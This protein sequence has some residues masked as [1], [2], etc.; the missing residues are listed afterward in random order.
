MTTGTFSVCCRVAYSLA[1]EGHAPEI[2]GMIHAKYYTPV[3]PLVQLVLETDFYIQIQMVQD[4]QTGLLKFVSKILFSLQV[5]MAIVFTFPSETSSLLDLFSFI[6]WSWT[7]LVMIAL[8]VMRWTKKDVKR[9][10]KVILVPSMEI[11]HSF[12]PTKEEIWSF[13]ESNQKHNK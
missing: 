6:D 10:F 2:F 9:T 8:I 7:L 1:R 13:K 12:C 4:Y 3:I 5:V 11:L